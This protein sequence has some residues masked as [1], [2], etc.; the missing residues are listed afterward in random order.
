MFCNAQ[1][2]D[3]QAK[4]IF[5]Q[6]RTDSYL[7]ELSEEQFIKKAVYYFSE[8]NALH[9]FREGNGRAQ[10]EFIRQLAYQAGYILHFDAVSEAEMITASID[11]FLCNYTKMEKLFAKIIS[12]SN[13]SVKAK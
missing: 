12:P 11:S 8:I 13:S 4:K 1:F 2:I 3:I 9:P 5:G 6:L 10:R 7:M